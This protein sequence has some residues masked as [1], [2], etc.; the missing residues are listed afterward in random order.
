MSSGHVVRR[1]I[2]INGSP[3]IGGNTSKV[4]DLIGRELG[5]Y[6]DVQVEV[7]HLKELDLQLCRGCFTCISRGEQFC[8]LKDGREDLE[9][10]MLEADGIVLASP[11]HV[12]NVSWMM[13][14]FIDRFCYTNHR[15]RFFRQKV[16]LVAVGGMDLRTTLRAMRPALGGAQVVSELGFA[17]LGWVQSP[18]AE[19]KKLKRLRRETKV[20][21]ESLRSEG[22]P[23]PRVGDLVRFRFLRSISQEVPEVFPADAAFYAERKDYYYETKVDPLTRAAA[24]LLTRIIMFISRDMGPYRG[25]RS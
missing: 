10:R 20:F 18:K 21:H 13:K 6:G 14:N 22:L 9:R 15:L 16:M 12:Q 7:I 3:R 17:N 4:L 23:R 5:S 8:P 19:S 24:A 11:L 25:E 2:M 1:V